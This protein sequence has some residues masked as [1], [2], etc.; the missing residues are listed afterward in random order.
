MGAGVIGHRAVVTRPHV[1]A[2]VQAGG[3]GGRMDVLT[4]ERAKPALPFAGVYQLVDFPLSNLANSGIT[5]VW[6]SV[7][8]Q[9]S[10]LEEQ[11][12]N[13]RPWDLDRNRGGLRLLMP[14]EGT[15]GADE[16]GFAKGNADE[17]YRLPRPGR[18]R[19]PRRAG[20]AERRPRLPLRLSWTPSRR[21]DVPV[22]SARSSRPTV[23][24]EDATDH[25]T[26]R[27]RRRRPGH[28]LR[29]QAGLARHR[30]GRHRDLRLRPGGPGRACS[31]SCTASWARTP[32]RATPGWVTSASTCSRVSS[33][34]AGSS[35]TRWTGYWRD[36]GQ[37]HK[38]LA[39]HHDVLTDDLGVL[40]DPD[41]PIL[42]HQQQRP[43][44]ASSTVRA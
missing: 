12:A 37:P 21:T 26:R 5:D 14:Q 8:F 4:R 13:G 44:R 40:G 3:A 15:G 17:L 16:E 30:D 34:A 43:R 41:W 39:A 27:E 6:L 23:P 1:L 11:V 35:R 20:R 22:P 29:L 24:V 10:A 31:S 18:R 2:L 38:Y 36:L 19:R 33:T 28:R 9:G 42:G 32:V 7:Q 25:A